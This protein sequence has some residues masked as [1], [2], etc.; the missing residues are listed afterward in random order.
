M[1]S[2]PLPS[3]SGRSPPSAS[4]TI[5]ASKRRGLWVGGMVPLGYESR[6]KRLV[7]NE[8]EAERVRLIFRRYLELGSLGKLLE[9]LRR[10]GMVTKVRHLANGRSIGGIPFTRGPLAYLLR[11][12][13]YIGEVLYR[14]EVCPGQQ[15]PILD[16]ELFNAVQQKLAAQ[17]H[18]LK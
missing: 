15:L 13:F 11:N 4:G 1:C 16:R 17:H 7:V 8:D 14:G 6:D 3:S 12:R 18:M 2:C 10:S 9:D 5:G